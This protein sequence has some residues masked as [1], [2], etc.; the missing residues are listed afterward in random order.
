LVSHLN[1][2]AS[3]FSLI[4]CL[5][6]IAVISE[7]ITGICGNPQCANKR[8]LPQISPISSDQQITLF[9]FL[10]SH[11]QVNLLRRLGHGSHRGPQ[12]DHVLDH[13]SPCGA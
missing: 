13:Q 2:F 8:N 12:H 6:L 7:T 11:L 5:K 3:L 4:L 9:E 10:S 1:S